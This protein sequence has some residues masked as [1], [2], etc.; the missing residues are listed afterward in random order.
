MTAFWD[1]IFGT[2]YVIDGREKITFGLDEK[3]GEGYDTVWSL[4]MNPVKLLVKKVMG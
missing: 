2:L 1:W 4:Y 3:E